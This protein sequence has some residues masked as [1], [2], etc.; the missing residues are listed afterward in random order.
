[1]DERTTGLRREKSVVKSKKREAIEATREGAG[2]A[3]LK[4]P[5]IKREIGNKKGF[6]WLYLVIY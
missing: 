3:E 5:E 4:K 2:E 6:G 1:M